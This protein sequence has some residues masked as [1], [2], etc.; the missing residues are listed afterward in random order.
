MVVNKIEYLWSDRKRHF[1]LPLSFTKYSLGDNRLF[2]EHGLFNLVEEEVLLY[3]VR[4]IKLTRS[5]GQRIFG[6]GTVTVYS[7]DKTLATLELK[8][9][10]DS[11]TIK[12]L[13]HSK[14]EEAKTTRRMRTTELLD[15]SDAVDDTDS[16]LFN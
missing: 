12:E 3:R 11:K 9:I 16:E 15:S 14:V 13:I 2:R 6:V 7:S 1:G 8:N 5:L 10:K 4:D